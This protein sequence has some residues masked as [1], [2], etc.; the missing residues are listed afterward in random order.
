MAVEHQQQHMV[1]DAVPSLLRG[2][3]QL[4]DLGLVEK[5]LLPLVGVGCLLNRLALYLSPVGHPHGVPHF[6][7]FH[8]E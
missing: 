6:T 3:Q 2:L 1:A 7:L 5:V 8:Q 4:L